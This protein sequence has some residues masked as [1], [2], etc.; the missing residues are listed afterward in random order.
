[1]K[2]FFRYTLITIVLIAAAGCAKHPPSAADSVAPAAESPS[3]AA[4]SS[5]SP[6]PALTPEEMKKIVVARVNGVELHMDALVQMMDAMS[7][8]IAPPRME[9]RETTRKKA[10][11]QLI[12]QEMALQQA[13]PASVRV[14]EREVNRAVAGIKG[15]DDDNLQNYLASRHLTLEELRAQLRRNI[16]LQEVLAKEINE[17]VVVT[18]EEMLKEYEDHK[19]RYAAEGKQMS[20]EEAKDQIEQKLLAV[21]RV[22]RRLEW[23]EELRKKAKIEIMESSNVNPRVPGNSSPV[24]R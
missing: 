6:S 4:E 20:F 1:M 17:K 9:P 16:R 7:A 10:L 15:H 18:N 22:K 21:A 24:E 19:D 13:P 23:E 8:A 14:L 2:S 5:A 12:F 3:P 11:D